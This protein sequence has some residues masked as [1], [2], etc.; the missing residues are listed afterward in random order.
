M[1]EVLVLFRLVVSKVFMVAMV[2][3]VVCDSN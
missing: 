3:L 2:V 1:S